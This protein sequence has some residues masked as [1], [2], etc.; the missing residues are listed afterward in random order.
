MPR[1]APIG[2][3]YPDWL[4]ARI[5]ESPWSETTRYIARRLQ[6]S[7]STVVRI[8]S[9]DLTCRSDNGRRYS[10][11]VLSEYDAAFLCILKCE[12][13]QASL[14]ECRLALEIERGKVVSNSTVSR[15]LKRLGMTRKKMQRYS[16]R[17]SEDSRVAWWTRPPH[18]GGCAGVDWSNMVDI[19]ESNVQFGDCQRRYGHSFS[20]IPARYQSLVSTL[21]HTL[22][23][24]FC[25]I[26]F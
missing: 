20:G 7:Q 10:D 13:P 6:V 19:D 26:I 18:M 21:Q 22:N 16:I 25:L 4:R 5:Q 2:V 15:E 1:L 24:L 8:L 11:C 3:P 23:H 12:Y 17:R 14:D 9:S